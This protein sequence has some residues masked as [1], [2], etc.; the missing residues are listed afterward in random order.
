MIIGISVNSSPNG[1]RKM[2][3]YK[4]LISVVALIALTGCA[5]TNQQSGQAIGAITGAIVGHSVGKGSGQAAA[6]FIGTVIGSEVGRN[7]GASMDR[8]PVVERE[9]IV[10]EIPA[11]AVSGRRYEEKRD[12]CRDIWNYNERKACY[13]GV[14]A[15][16]RAEEQRRIREAYDRGYKGK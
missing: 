4:K 12:V 14:E 5:S 6:T 16:E 15:R 11:P 1:K 2:K 7:V 8:P 3:M 9:V 13:R 10:K